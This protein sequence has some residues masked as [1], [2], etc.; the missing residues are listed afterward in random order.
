MF[1]IIMCSTVENLFV[2]EGKENAPILVKAKLNNVPVTMELDTGAAR[3]LICKTNYL[4]FYTTKKYTTINT[5]KGLFSYNR[6]CFGISSAPGIFQRAMDNLL[7]GLPGVLCYLD[8]ILICGSSE[9]D[10]FEK[11]TKVL[12]NLESTGLKLKPD[13]CTFALIKFII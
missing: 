9:S 8:D 11:L 7:K 5:H 2:D 10:H 1:M 13:K 12:T 4:K 3:T 6:L